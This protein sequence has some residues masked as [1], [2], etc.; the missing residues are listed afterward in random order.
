MS[1]CVCVCVC[2]W[3]RAFRYVC[4][5]ASVSGCARKSTAGEIQPSTP[6]L[7]V[8]HPLRERLTYARARMR[9]STHHACSDPAPCSYTVFI[10]V[11]KVVIGYSYRV[12]RR[13]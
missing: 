12:L 2:E 7:L 10:P 1:V 9:N 11:V 6:P 13:L 3:V 5:Y 4:A 8:V